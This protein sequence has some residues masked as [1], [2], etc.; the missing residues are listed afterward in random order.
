MLGFTKS[1]LNG[2]HSTRNWPLCGINAKLKVVVVCIGYVRWGKEDSSSWFYKI[3]K[4]R[5][6]FQYLDPYFNLKWYVLN[7]LI[8]PYSIG[9]RPL[10][11]VNAKLKVVCIGYVRWGKEDSSWWLHKITDYG[12]PLKPFFI[13]IL[14]LGRQFGQLNFGAFVVFSANFINTQFGTVIPL[15]MFSINQP[16]FLQK[17]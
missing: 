7:K 15:S 16:L 10:C 9:N 17:N 5:T 13:K 4:S 12:R 14:N 2:P 3:I 11:S 1:R 8:D 6:N